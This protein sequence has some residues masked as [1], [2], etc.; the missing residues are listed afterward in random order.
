MTRPPSAWATNSTV[1]SSRQKKRLNCS[2]PEWSPGSLSSCMHVLVN[3][4]GRWCNWRSGWR[5]LRCNWAAEA[6]DS[7]PA[8][9][10]NASLPSITSSGGIQ[11]LSPPKNNIQRARR[12][13]KGSRKPQFGTLRGRSAEVFVDGE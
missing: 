8:E 7:G 10:L 11:V 13:W 6:G 1:A 9:R 3:K 4:G 12:K 5:C 2:R